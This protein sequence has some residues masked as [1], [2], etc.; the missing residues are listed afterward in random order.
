MRPGFSAE[1]IAYSPNGK[2]LAYVDFPGFRLYRSASDGSGPM[3]LAPGVDAYHP[4]WSPDG[5]T[6]AFAGRKANSLEPFRVW[7]VPS[8]G[9]KAAPLAAIGG[10]GFDPTWSPD[11]KKI[12]FAPFM[13]WRPRSE[14][15]VQILD[16]ETG[17]VEAVPGGEGK[18]STRWSP[19]GTMIAALDHWDRGTT[20]WVYR[21]ETKQWTKLTDKPF[22]FQEWSRD[23]RYIY[24]GDFSGNPQW[25]QPARV[26]VRTKKLDSFATRP[27]FPMAANLQFWIGWTPEM[28][29]LC[30]RDMTTTEI[31]RIDL[32]R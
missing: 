11:G 24:G 30:L 25:P 32:D 4:C 13:E 15:F 9:G 2:G 26:D 6:I 17:K 18:F 10:P 29:P 27:T 3:E 23:S 20:L 16:L 8:S 12:V 7:T 28:E 22:G 1:G 14:H 5:K 31:F 21:F 19:D